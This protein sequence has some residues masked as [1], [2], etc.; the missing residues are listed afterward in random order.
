MI[1]C[2][3]AQETPLPTSQRRPALVIVIA[4]VPMT[5]LPLVAVITMMLIFT[6]LMM[7]TAVA[8]LIAVPVTWH[9]LTLIPVFAHEVDRPA[10]G[11]VLSTVP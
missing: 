7:L 3:C 1:H 11:V 2:S 6:P 10:A 9:V 8:M 4:L 5:V